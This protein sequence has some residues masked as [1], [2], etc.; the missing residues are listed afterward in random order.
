MNEIRKNAQWSFLSLKEF[1]YG[2]LS[3]VLVLRGCS[4]QHKPNT[5]EIITIQFKYTVFKKFKKDL[6]IP[7]NDRT[8]KGK[9]K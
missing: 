8:K 7:K 4:P 5:F 1:S 6:T 2:Q 9:W 3:T